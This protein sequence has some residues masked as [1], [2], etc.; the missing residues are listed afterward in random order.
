MGN[1]QA[2]KPDA[3]AFIFRLGEVASHEFGYEM[4]FYS[5]LLC[6]LN[7]FRT[8]LMDES[9]GMPRTLFPEHFDMTIPQNR[10]VVDE[11]NRLPVYDPK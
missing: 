9:Q 2:G 11:I 6:H 5:C 3:S 1:L 4:G 8:D 10:R 7:P